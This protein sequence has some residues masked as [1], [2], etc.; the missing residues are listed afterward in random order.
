M[1]TP[2]DMKAR[3]SVFYADFNKEDN[4]NSILKPEFDRDLLVKAV[5]D[6]LKFIKAQKYS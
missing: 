1:D 3:M 6:F 4:Y 2:A 5:D